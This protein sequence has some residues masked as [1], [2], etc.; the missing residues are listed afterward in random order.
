MKTQLFHDWN[1]QFDFGEKPI[2]EDEIVP[3]LHAS[4][5]YD[6]RDRLYRVGVLK[7]PSGSGAL[8]EREEP[9]L[10]VYDYFCDQS[11]RVLQKRSLGEGAEVALIVD[12][13]YDDATGS[14]TERA[15]SPDG[16]LSR[17]I[18]RPLASGEKGRK[19][20]EKVKGTGGKRRAK[21]AW[22]SG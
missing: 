17:S 15:W 13:E 20:S 22:S 10:A 1:W 7:A 19:G 12:Y 3:R 11:G 16:G 8:K 18:R 5:Y 2:S 21:P 9:E 6:H 14:V 4:A